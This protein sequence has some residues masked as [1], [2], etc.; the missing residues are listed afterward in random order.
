VRKEL[1]NGLDT[2]EGVSL[3]GAISAAKLT[4]TAYDVFVSPIVTLAS[5]IA[6]DFLLALLK[7]LITAR[8][9]LA[10]I[11]AD[12]ATLLALTNILQ[13]WSDQAKK[14]AQET[15]NHHSDRPGRCSN[16]SA[17]FATK[18][19]G[20]AGETQRADDTHTSCIGNARTVHDA[21]HNNDTHTLEDVIIQTR[22]IDARLDFFQ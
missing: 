10:Q 18:D 17:R 7:A 1:I 2:L 6:D 5:T 13:S 16:L 14:Y 22:V 11:N 4:R 8:K 19:S 12:N 3:E 9:W 21:W 20:R 15:A